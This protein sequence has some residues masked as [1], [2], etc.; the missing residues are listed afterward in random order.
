MIEGARRGLLAVF[1]DTGEDRAARIEL[2]TRYRRATDL[3]RQAEVPVE[4]NA[5]RLTVPYQ[6]VAVLLLE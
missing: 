4:E 5:I 1:N 2:P 3:H 6:D